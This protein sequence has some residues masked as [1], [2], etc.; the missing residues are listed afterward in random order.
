MP[1]QPRMRC[2]Y[3]DPPPAKPRQAK[4]KKVLTEEEKAEA[5]VL[6]EARKKVRDAKN[7]WEASLVS[8][9]S[10]GDFRFPIGTMAMYKS[11]AKSSYSLSEKEIL[12]LP[13]E[14]IPGSSKTFVSQADTKALAQRKFAAG[15]SKPGIDL[16]PPEFGLR[17]FKKRK[18]ATSAEGRTS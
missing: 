2:A 11:D 9:T 10:K 5:K 8:W 7:A 17:L 18:T 16:D 3:A 13:H 15:V 12:T 1:R 14:S 4:P 6:K